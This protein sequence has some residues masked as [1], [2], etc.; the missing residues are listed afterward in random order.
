MC[1]WHLIWLPKLATKSRFRNI[2]CHFRLYGPVLACMALLSI[3][4]N[5]P[6]FRPLKSKQCMFWRQCCVEKKTTEVS[7]LIYCRSLRTCGPRFYLTYSITS[8]ICHVWNTK[9]NV[10]SHIW[11][12]TT[13]RFWSTVSNAFS[14]PHWL[15][16][17]H[18]FMHTQVHFSNVAHNSLFFLSKPQKYTKQLILQFWT[19]MNCTIQTEILQKL[20]I[21][22]VLS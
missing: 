4:Q 21:L 7:N 9:I 3:L 5:N 1:F 10:F 12:T 13:S 18:S 17:F 15:W 22:C 19:L 20:Q 16:E 2:S 8:K 6:L 14:V 11:Q